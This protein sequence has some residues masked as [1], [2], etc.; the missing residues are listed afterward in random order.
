[1]KY[2][3]MTLFPEMIEASTNHSILKRAKED[4]LIKIHTY[5]I[6]DFATNKHKNVD[7][8]QYGGGAGMG[9]ASSATAM[10]KISNWPAARSR[11]SCSVA[12]NTSGK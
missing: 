3:V 10:P 5:N 2:H 9:G 4:G 12:C 8:Y 7:D 6:R 11:A 1:M